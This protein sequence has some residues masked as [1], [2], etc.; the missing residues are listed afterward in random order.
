MLPFYLSAL[1]QPRLTIGCRLRKM[2]R[3]RLRTSQVLRCGWVLLLLLCWET[4]PSV[5]SARRVLP[6]S[7][8][9]S[10]FLH[11]ATQTCVVFAVCRDGV[12]TVV[13]HVDTRRVTQPLE[14]A[15]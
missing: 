8:L 10:L 1:W 5:F 7:P 4:V 6:L 15:F 2:F 14:L 13:V 9:C 11:S 12:A 3:P